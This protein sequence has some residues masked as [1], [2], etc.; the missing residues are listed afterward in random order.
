M[1]TSLSSWNE[2]NKNE[3]KMKS[4]RGVWTDV[5]GTNGVDEKRRQRLFIIVGY[6]NSIFICWMF[7]FV[8][9]RKQNCKILKLKCKSIFKALFHT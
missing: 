2:E 3:K 1:F 9:C 6:N 7:V 5:Y 4:Y 8:Y